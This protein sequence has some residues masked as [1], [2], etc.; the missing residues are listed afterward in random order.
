MMD[1]Q[2][3]R[4]EQLQLMIH[5]SEIMKQLKREQKDCPSEQILLKWAGENA[6]CK[7]IGTALCRGLRR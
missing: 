2:L 5:F 4:S 7:P 3:E 1:V 6:D